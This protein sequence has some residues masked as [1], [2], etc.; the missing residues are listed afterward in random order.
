MLVG[1]RG[2]SLGACP[3]THLFEKVRVARSRHK[4]PLDTAIVHAW[5]EDPIRQRSAG[6]S[7]GY[8]F[9]AANSRR[10]RHHESPK[11]GSQ[12]LMVLQRQHMGDVLVGAHHHQG[13]LASVDASHIEN[14]RAAF[15]IGAEDLSIVA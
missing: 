12:G 9:T 11:E 7:H 5:M 6:A 2:A 4:R 8:F 13:P 10:D 14:I 1:E 15:Q 3:L